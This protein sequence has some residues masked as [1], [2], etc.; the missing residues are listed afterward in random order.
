[1]PQVMRGKLDDEK[2][3]D[4]ELMKILKA[5]QVDIVDLEVVEEMS[6]A[7]ERY[8][9]SAIQ[10]QEMVTDENVAAMEAALNRQDARRFIERRIKA[11][12]QRL[13]L[14]A[15]KHFNQI[16]HDQKSLFQTCSRSAQF[17]PIRCGLAT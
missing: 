6:H 2:Q 11:L 4:R 9:N 3:W 15:Q 8:D 1:M 17:P 16:K 14:Y 13:G 7:K 12:D 10:M 5:R